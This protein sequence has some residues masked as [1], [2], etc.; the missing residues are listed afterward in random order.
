[1]HL[2][3]LC[4]LFF[5]VAQGQRKEKKEKKN[6]WSPC[7]SISYITFSLLQ[8]NNEVH[9]SKGP[10]QAGFSQSFYSVLISRDV[11]Q[12]QG[13]LKGKAFNWHISFLF[14]Q[15]AVTIRQLPSCVKVSKRKRSSL[16]VQC[17]AVYIIFRWV[18]CCICKADARPGKGVRLTPVN[19]FECLKL[20]TFGNICSCV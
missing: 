8:R 16:F 20:R 11:L 17:Q 14:C 2:Y 6:Q 3:T 15:A 4:W 18:R 5:P 13:L 7:L 9:A 1:M 10:C 19:W 12:G